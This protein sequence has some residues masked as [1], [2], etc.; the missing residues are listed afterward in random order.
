[1]PAWLPNA[2]AE[3]MPTT[4]PAAS[5]SAPPELPGLIAASVWIASRQA[6]AEPSGLLTHTGRF[7]AE[8]IPSVTDPAYP[9]GEPIAITGS[10]TASWSESPSVATV[11]LS[12]GTWMTA[13]SLVGS[14]PT[15][16][17]VARASSLNS[18]TRAVAPWTTWLLVRTYPF[19]SIT[20]PEPTPE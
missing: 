9:S 5:T 1:M 12:A 6:S 18:T 15:T 2:A 4:A 20:T 13:R 14:R 19:L 7:L 16:R 17:A 3:L 11:S 8:T 10:P